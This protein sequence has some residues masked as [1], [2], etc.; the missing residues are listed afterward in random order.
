[1]RL[2]VEAAD[3]GIWIRDLGRNEIWATEKWRAI[4]AF[5]PEERLDLDTILQRIHPE[6]RDTVRSVLTQ[7]IQ[8]DGIY[9]VIFR[10]LP[11]NG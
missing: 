9:E 8:G 1:M 4:F 11:T 5:E 10:L 6:D 2:A 7:A 3:F